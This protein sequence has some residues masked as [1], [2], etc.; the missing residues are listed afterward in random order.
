MKIV[1]AYND[2]DDAR[3]A[4]ACA[5]ALAGETGAEL[6]LV[7]AVPAPA[8]PSHASPKVV[9]E[10]M[11]VADAAARKQ[12]DA[13]VAGLQAKGVRATDH[14]RRWFPVDTAIDRAKELGADL[15][16]IGRRGSSRATQLLIGTNSSELVRLS[17]VSVMVVRKGAVGG[18][19]PVLVGIDGSRPSLRALEVARSL[20]PKAPVVACHVGDAKA[21]AGVDRAKVNVIERQGDP[22]QQLL[23]ELA[24]GDYRAIVLGPRGLG[25]LEGLLLG[26]VTEKVLQLATKPVVVAR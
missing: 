8:V 18:T 24:G 9:E 23:A 22:A 14:T 4:V 13:V 17:P 11:A 3:A 19:G 20:W 15:I 7:Y 25:Q 1:V 26:S 12:L 2:S 6:D 5:T 16:V 21:L 10:L